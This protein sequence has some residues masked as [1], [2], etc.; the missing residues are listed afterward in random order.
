MGEYA[1]ILIWAGL[2]AGVALLLALF[3]V[4]VPPRRP[5]PTEVASP[6]DLD[7][8]LGQFQ[9]HAVLLVSFGFLALLLSAWAAGVGALGR[10]GLG[11][12]A[13]VTAPTICI[14]MFTSVTFRFQYNVAFQR[15][16]AERS[17]A[18]FPTENALL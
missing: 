8:A 11:V 15:D 2:G 1:A 13:L 12:A 16:F 9:F 18:K 3:H 17:G 4:R 10:T 14:S 6:V 7:Q 5:P